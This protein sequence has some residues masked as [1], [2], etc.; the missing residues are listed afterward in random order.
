MKTKKILALLLAI[1]ML[2][3]PAVTAQANSLGDIDGNNFVDAADARLAL[4]IAVGLEDRMGPGTPQYAAADADGNGTV[5]AADARILLRVAVGLESLHTGADTGAPLSSKEIYKKAAAYTFE[6]NVVTADYEAIGS[7]FA[8]SKDGCI[9]TNYHVIEDAEKITVTD[10]SGRAY[11]LTEIAAFDRHLDIAVLRVKETLTPAE[12]NTADYE[13]G[14]VVYT[15]GSSN[16]YTGTFA[17]GVISNSAVSL[18]DYRPDMTFIQT[19]APISGGNSGGPLIDSYG[20]VLGINTLTDEMGQN[21]NFAIP[22]SYL[23]GLDRSHPLTPEQFSQAEY[24][25]CEAELVFGKD[26]FCMR[27][28][29]TAAFI[30]YITSPQ[31]YV[32]RAK[33]SDDNVTVAVSYDPD[34]GYL[35]LYATARGTCKN[36][37]LTLYAEETGAVCANVRVS[38]APDGDINYMSAYGTPDFGAVTGV[39]PYEVNAEPTVPY[40]GLVYDGSA[41]TKASGSAAKARSAYF[42]ALESAGFTQTGK[43]TRLL[44][45]Y[46]TYSYYNQRTDINV[47]YTENLLL[48]QLR[49]VTVEVY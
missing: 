14:D 16:G 3:V 36:A 24:G 42:A 2:L 18:A 9:V 4:R 48:G 34:W 21:L 19:S 23:A 13:T 45:A 11:T 17:N 26:N 20:R 31:G 38:V 30:Y 43:T 8:I 39:C 15:L 35:A 46:V 5:E 25:R 37:V 12:L 33:S 7:G 22:V 32:P 10:L 44:G 29:S 28:G 40:A 49:N 27:P 1:A 41:V 47:D 6:I